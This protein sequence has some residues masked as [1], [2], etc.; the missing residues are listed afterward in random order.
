MLTPKMK[1]HTGTNSEEYYEAILETT[2][3]KKQDF[4]SRYTTWRQKIIEK[5]VKVPPSVLSTQDA[6][7]TRNWSKYLYERI[8]TPG[9]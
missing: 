3:R 2:W 6:F 8:K 4:W 1:L 9:S 5:S 7:K